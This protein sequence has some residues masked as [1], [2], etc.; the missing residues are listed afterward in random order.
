MGVRAL[1]VSGKYF[2]DTVEYYCNPANAEAKKEAIKLG[3]E[4]K[5]GGQLAHKFGIANDFNIDHYKRVL[6]GWHPTKGWDNDKSPRLKLNKNAMSFNEATNEFEHGEKEHRAGTELLFTVHKT[7]TLLT[8][9]L[10]QEDKEKFIKIKERA[11]KKAMAAVASHAKVKLG[12]DGKEVISASNNILWFG[13]NHL[14]TRPTEYKKDGADVD[15][16]VVNY[17]LKDGKLLD[18]HGNIV[19]KDYA[20]IKKLEGAEADPH[21]HIHVLVANVTEVKGNPYALDNSDIVK[22]IE[23]YDAIFQAELRLGIET[24]L[25]IKTKD[26]ILK[27]DENNRFKVLK[28]THSF[29]IESL[30]KVAEK[31]S[32]RGK[33]IGLLMS[34]AGLSK[35]KAWEST[36]KK[37]DTELTPTDLIKRFEERFDELEHKLPD[38]LMNDRLIQSNQTVESNEVKPK[39]LSDVELIQ[40]VHDQAKDATFSYEVFK[41]T[42]LKNLVC[43]PGFNTIEKV[44]KKIEQLFES[45]VD[46][47]YYIPK[48]LS[49]EEKVLLEEY[50]ANNE[51]EK[52]N[53]KT[54]LDTSEILQYRKKQAQAIIQRKCKFTST[55]MIE[56]ENKS[57]ENLNQSNHTETFEADEVDQFIKD[58]EAKITQELKDKEPNVAKHEAINFQYSLSQKAAIFSFI[59][60]GNSAILQAPAGSGKSTALKAIY[61]FYTNKGYT[62]IAT[63]PSAEATKNLKDSIGMQDSPSSIS[64]NVAELIHAIDVKKNLNIFSSDRKNIVLSDEMGTCDSVALNKLTSMIKQNGAKAYLVGDSE[65][66]Q[67]IGMAGMFKRL[68]NVMPVAKLTEINRQKE[69]WQKEMAMNLYL[70]KGKES[71]EALHKNKKLVITKTQ[72]ERQQQIVEDY[73]ADTNTWQQKTGIA[74]T[75]ADSWMLNNLV[76]KELIKQ[77]KIGNPVQPGEDP[78]KDFFVVKGNDERLREFGVKDRIIFIENVLEENEET[79]EKTKLRNSQRGEVLEIKKRKYTTTDENGKEVINETAT[80][81]IQLDDGSIRKVVNKDL[82]KLQHSYFVNSYKQQGNTV[83][84]SYYYTTAGSLLDKHEAYVSL[85]RHKSD[86]K[87]YMDFEDISKEEN[88]RDNESTKNMQKAV[89]GIAKKK[90]INLE[91]IED[92]DINSFKKCRDFLDD[93]YYHLGGGTDKNK[94]AVEKYM[95]QCVKDLAESAQKT[96]YKKTTAD[97]DLAPIREKTIYSENEINRVVANSEDNFNNIERID[98]PI[99]LPKEKAN[100]ASTDKNLKERFKNNLNLTSLNKHLNNIEMLNN[101]NDITI[102]KNDS[103]ITLPTD[104]KLSEIEN[105]KAANAKK[106]LDDN[107]NYKGLLNH[108]LDKDT[109]HPI[110]QEVAKTLLKKPYFYHKV[111]AD[112]QLEDILDRFTKLPITTGDVNTLS[113]FNV[114]ED[115]LKCSDIQY[116][117]NTSLNLLLN[118]FTKVTVPNVDIDNQQSDNAFFYTKT[119]KQADAII[120]YRHV[121]VPDVNFQNQDTGNTALLIA[122]NRDKPNADFVKWLISN[123]AQTGAYTLNK[124]KQATDNAMTLA[125]KKDKPDLGVLKVLAQ[126][127]E[128][129]ASKTDGSGL[130]AENIILNNNHLTNNEKAKIFSTIYLASHNNEPKGFPLKMFYNLNREHDNPNIKPIL[131]EANK[132]IYENL[133]PFLEEYEKV[134]NNY[135]NNKNINMFE[136]RLVQIITFVLEFFDI[137][138]KDVINKIEKLDIE[139]NSDMYI[140]TNFNVPTNAKTLSAVTAVQ[141]KTIKQAPSLSLQQQQLSM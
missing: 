136:K 10:N 116:T 29:E 102:E 73:L 89:M 109:L 80:F 117:T 133:N 129:L 103:K 82:D 114:M 88:T 12:T 132:E 68:Q 33:E 40:M 64:M 52:F 135:K 81:T 19:E 53:D 101:K 95:L 16:E 108:L 18:L 121:G 63:A 100:P 122:C 2:N 59:A 31:F 134:T 128:Y 44:E 113:Y 120:N 62:V 27:A 38:L 6:A 66:K 93:Y 9:S 17:E 126:S 65:Q 107:Q 90:H 92:F 106:Q 61:E 1:N 36:R 5:I 43:K 99:E 20:H 115:K 21:D 70:G 8:Y 75:K 118:N 7:V 140:K 71:I 48:D 35:E 22:N 130:K 45:M 39:T 32:N 97:Y 57:I 119:V 3:L 30:N 23:L 111:L 110:K 54:E 25:H 76:R 112:P 104:N 24:E 127:N 69:S 131:E 124:Y 49:E 55:W 50:F 139:E 138:K 91:E 14:E 4:P 125:L 56:L 60:N 28:R 34:N 77:G 46:K 86:V 15:N 123:G 84:T 47:N 67:G 137:T 51:E 11:L 78:K 141:N 105:K 58:F 94:S 13:F 83:N 26:T 74:V 37:K 87:V 72:R 79:K 96:N 85:T 98:A 42:L 41:A